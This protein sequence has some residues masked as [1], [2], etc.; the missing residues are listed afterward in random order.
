MN[1]KD[2]LFNTHCRLGILSSELAKVY[3]HDPERRVPRYWL[4][5]SQ[6]VVENPEFSV[7]WDADPTPEP[8]EWRDLDDEPMPEGPKL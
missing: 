7:P 1:D 2:K 6:R 8:L 3:R 5:Y 4:D